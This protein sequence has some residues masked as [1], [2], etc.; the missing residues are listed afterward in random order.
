MQHLWRNMDGCEVYYPELKKLL[1]QEPP[2]MR[3]NSMYAAV[4]L[5]TSRFFF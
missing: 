2:R 1:L 3:W 5:F 4:K